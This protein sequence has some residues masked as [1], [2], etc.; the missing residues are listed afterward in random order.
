[1]RNYDPDTVLSSPKGII[2]GEKGIK[3]SKKKKKNFSHIDLVSI[4][5]EKFYA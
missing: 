4:G 2:K 1:M 3:T 5:I